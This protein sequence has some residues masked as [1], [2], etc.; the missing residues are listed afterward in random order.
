MS[1]MRKA[2]HPSLAAV[3]LNRAVDHSPAGMAAARLNRAVDRSPA[4]VRLNRA[5]DH[6]PV[7]VRLNLAE[8]RPNRAAN[9]GTQKRYAKCDIIDRNIE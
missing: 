2:A 1:R 8:D 6:S 5:V 3:R 9:K 4:A 7:A